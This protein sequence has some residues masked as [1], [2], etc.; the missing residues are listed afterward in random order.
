M[1]YLFLEN[2]VQVDAKAHYHMY[3]LIQ[4]M[5]YIFYFYSLR[6]IK[7]VAATSFIERREYLLKSYIPKSP[8]HAVSA[9][10]IP[11]V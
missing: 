3:A 8:K 2:Q 7:L 1:A 11:Y 9:A 5:T 10:S 6:S 4:T